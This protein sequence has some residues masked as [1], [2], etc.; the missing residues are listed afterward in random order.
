VIDAGAGA[1]AQKGERR[2]RQGPMRGEVGAKSGKLARRRQL[3][4]PEQ[5]GGLLEGGVP[6]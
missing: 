1:L 3:S 4:V 5:P 2:G 6:G